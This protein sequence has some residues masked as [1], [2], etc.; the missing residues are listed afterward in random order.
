VEGPKVIYRDRFN[1]LGVREQTYELED[2]EV[3]KIEDLT[4][5]MNQN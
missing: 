4:K 3:K 2:T 1:E 5:I